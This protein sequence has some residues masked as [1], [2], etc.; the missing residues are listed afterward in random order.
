MLSEL[1]SESPSCF[2]SQSSSTSHF[3][4]STSLTYVTFLKESSCSGNEEAKLNVSIGR[5]TYLSDG[6][7]SLNGS[8]TGN[9]FDRIV[10]A[11]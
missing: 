6:H 2:L 8:I 5:T 4:S 10:I 3:D 7:I 1:F 11:S 9:L